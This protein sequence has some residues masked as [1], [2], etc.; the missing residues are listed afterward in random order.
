MAGMSSGSRN[1]RRK[2]KGIM[3]Y[4]RGLAEGETAGILLEM[5]EEERVTMMMKESEPGSGSSSNRHSL[6]PALSTSEWEEI[7]AGERAKTE[8]ERQLVVDLRFKLIALQG[9]MDVF[10]AEIS[11]LKLDR[12]TAEEEIV[13]LKTDIDNYITEIEGLHIKSDE[14]KAAN[15]QIVAGLN[16]QIER[17]KA[18]LVDAEGILLQKIGQI[19]ELNSE[20]AM[21]NKALSIAGEKAEEMA[22]RMAEKVADI[23]KMVDERSKL[24]AAH[25]KFAKESRILA[26]QNETLIAS[27]KNQ[28]IEITEEKERLV[29]EAAAEL[30]E[31]VAAHELALAEL[32]AQHANTVLQHEMLVAEMNIKYTDLE[33]EYKKMEQRYRQQRPVQQHQ[34]SVLE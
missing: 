27:Q 5:T 9:E 10:T 6:P 8:M 2:T 28:I 7:L 21:K 4:K 30:A 1:Q 22:L 15:E 31:T 16:L 26:Q 3:N 17:L 23:A 34:P 18:A 11:A 29:A 24:L 32:V 12:Q 33:E 13:A 20:L 25:E 19:N 14:A